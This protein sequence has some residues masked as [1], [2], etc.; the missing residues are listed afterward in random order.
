[1]VFSRSLFIK[2]LLLLLFFHP[3]MYIQPKHD[4]AT[5]KTPNAFFLQ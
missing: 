4:A 2:T 5:V 3:C 1:M